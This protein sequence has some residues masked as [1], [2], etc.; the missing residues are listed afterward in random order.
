MTVDDMAV[1]QI[2]YIC[3]RNASYMIVARMAVI[4]PLPSHLACS[5]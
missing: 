5:C 2:R 4:A 1:Q 3:Y